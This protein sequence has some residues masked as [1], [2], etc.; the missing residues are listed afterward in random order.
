V[1]CMKLKRSMHGSITWDCSTAG[2]RGCNHCPAMKYVEGGW[3]CSKND[4]KDA[5]EWMK[6]CM[7]YELEGVEPRDM[8]RR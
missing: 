1:W 4:R 8:P 5:S 7:N 6:R 2:N 3:S